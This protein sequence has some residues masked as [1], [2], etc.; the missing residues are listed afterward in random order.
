MLKDLN[1]EVLE[2]EGDEKFPDSCFVEDTA[3]M[4]PHC[5]IISNPGAKTRKG[6]ID[7]M[8]EHLSKFHKNIERI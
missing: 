1:L 8:V 4:T 2:L 6:E 7:S 3:L 5:V